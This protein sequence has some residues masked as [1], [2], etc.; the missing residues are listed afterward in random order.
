MN[1][2]NF[3]KAIRTSDFLTPCVKIWSTGFALR[4]DVWHTCNN[5]CTYCFARGLE[6]GAFNRLKILWKPNIGRVGDVAALA[7]RFNRI[8]D[9]GLINV[10]DFIDWAIL[11]RWFP[12]VGTMG[13]QFQ[14]PDLKYGYTMFFLKLLEAYRYPLFICTKGN[15]LISNEEYYDALVDLKK[16]GLI[17]DVSLIGL[18]DEKLRKFEPRAPLASERL[19]LIKRLCADGV[20]VTISVRPFL[21]GVTD[22]NFEEFIETL[23]QAGVKSIHLRQFYITGILDRSWDWF[24]KQNK[25]KL[26]HYGPGWKY[27]T[28]FLLQFFKRAMEITR[29]YGVVTTGSTRL[30]FELEGTSQKM[31]FELCNKIN[32]ERLFPYTILPIFREIKRRINEPQVLYYSERLSPLFK[33]H[34]NPMLDRE[35]SI[36]RNTFL[37]LISGAC[38]SKPRVETLIPFKDIVR[39]SIWDG[40][41]GESGYINATRRI[42]LI[43]KNGE[44][45]RD[46]EGHLV[47]FYCPPELLPSNVDPYFAHHKVKSKPAIDY[48][49]VKELVGEV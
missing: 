40:W 39:K 34:P 48:Q 11:N 7:K 19:N 41:L 46:G 17:V 36:T 3:Y 37:L 42:Y 47:Y 26:S 8:F 30:F 9:Q 15:L 29:K 27:K 2:I 1:Q 4:Y 33:A 14:V 24:V 18:N 23:C 16:N 38:L 44:P 31:D 6:F 21:L 28:D 25:D 12:E 49:T 13:E 5:F 32:Q 20:D 22:E 43:T 35:I 10:H 45:L